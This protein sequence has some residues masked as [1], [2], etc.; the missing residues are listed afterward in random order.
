[1]L[2][3]VR[4]HVNGLATVSTTAIVRRANAAAHPKELKDVPKRHAWKIW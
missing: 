3:C 2:P 1:M 4:F